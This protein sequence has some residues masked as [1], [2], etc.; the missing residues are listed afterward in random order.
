[1]PIDPFAALNAILRAE[2]SRTCAP[3]PP[4]AP[5]LPEAPERPDEPAAVL[6][7]KARPLS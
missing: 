2:V 4:E 5:A 3:T 7:P 6:E 1:M